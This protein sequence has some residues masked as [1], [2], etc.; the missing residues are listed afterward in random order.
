M[1]SQLVDEPDDFPEFP[2]L[3]LPDEEVSVELDPPGE[4]F[5]GPLERPGRESE[6]E[7]PFVS[8]GEDPVMVAD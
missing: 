7:E 1:A 4:V 3:P 5:V 6:A 8:V 2:E